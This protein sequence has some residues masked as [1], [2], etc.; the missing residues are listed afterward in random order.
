MA[1]FRVQFDTTKPAGE[2]VHSLRAFDG[3]NFN[4][5]LFSRDGRIVLIQRS[6]A[7]R[8]HMT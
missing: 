5:G 6:Y 2:R 4:K 7:C 1:G 3:E 8:G